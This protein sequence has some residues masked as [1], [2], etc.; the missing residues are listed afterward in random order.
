LPRLLLIGDGADKPR[1]QAAIRQ[2]GVQDHC[3]LPGVQTDI[4][5]WLQAMDVFCLS[6]DTEGTS[7]SLLEAGAASLPSVV[8]DVGGNPEVVIDGE[9]G[10]VVPRGDAAALCRAI[11]RL[12]DSSGDRRAYGLCA[13]RRVQAEYSMQS[14]ADA[15]ISVYESSVAHRCCRR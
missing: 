3:V 10:L 7:I 13:A 8:T 1:I 9:S 4:G 14:M 12:M 2:F 11:A 6:S 5:T 15:Y